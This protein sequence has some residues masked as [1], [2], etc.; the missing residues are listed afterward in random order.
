MIKK[1][2]LL[3]IV[4]GAGCFAAEAHAQTVQCIAAAGQWG[5]CPFVQPVVVATVSGTAQVNNKVSAGAG[6]TI[7]NA[8]PG[9]TS[10]GNS[11]LC[12]GFEGVA[13]TPVFTDAQSN[14]YIVAESSGA[15]AP[16]YTVALASNIV[17]GT[18]DTVTLTTSS[19]SAAFTCYELKG[20]IS[21][22]Q[23]WDYAA[24]AQGTSATLV[25]PQESAS[26]TNDFVAVGV[27]MGAGTVNATPSLAG[28]PSALTTVD[29]SN[30]APLG[31]AALSVFYTAHA[32]VTNSPTFTQP[33]SISASETYSSVLV[34]V[35]PPSVS[36]VGNVQDPCQQGPGTPGN[37]NLT[38]SGQI[39]TGVAGKQTYIC[40]MDLISATAQNIAL[41]EGTG[42]TCASNTLGMAGGTTAA[43][44]WNLAANGGFVTGNGGFWVF[45]TAVA[46]DNVCLLLSSTGQT[47]GNFRQVQQ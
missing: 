22:G 10:A 6:T 26:I 37:I 4:I 11:I 13:A 20:A 7:T 46:G 36:L 5:P 32:N 31:T 47:S 16:G 12:I 2:L 9:T 42:T 34:A 40:S 21:V 19:G 33:V 38:A 30:T 41:V 39:I 25:F 28:V 3:A 44:G 15:A 18:T 23:V 24:V 43:T 45:K 8:F 29:Q 14:T 17:G 1:L 35:K 27:G